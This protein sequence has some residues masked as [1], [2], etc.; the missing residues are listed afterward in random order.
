MSLGGSGVDDGFC[1]APVIGVQTSFK[2]VP[3]ADVVLKLAQLSLAHFCENDGPTSILCTQALPVSCRVCWGPRSVESSIGDLSASAQEKED[4]YQNSFGETE[5]TGDDLEGHTNPA[6]IGDQE[7]KHHTPFKVLGNQGECASCT[8]S[9]P[10][11]YTVKLPPGSPGSPRLD[12]S[13]THGSP[14]LRSRQLIPSWASQYS[15]DSETEDEPSLQHSSPDSFTSDTTASSYHEH[16]LECRTT[17]SPV[18]PNTYSMLRRACIQTLSCEQLPRGL[19]SGRLLFDDQI[20]GLTV[21]WKFRLPDPHA[22]GRYRQYALLA[23]AGHGSRRAMDAAPQIWAS[24][25]RIVNGVLADTERVLNRGKCPYTGKPE[26]SNVSSFLTGRSLDP[27]GFPRRNGVNSMRARSLVEIVGDEYFFPRLHL[28]FTCLLRSLA[29]RFGRV[30][31]QPP[32]DYE[33]SQE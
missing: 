20:N 33:S 18:D 1:Y 14:I 25:E 11:Q 7:V 8:F 32:S 31:L 6:I 19:T 4:G 10:K 30:K 24:F 29:E 16:K 12:G 9:V 2:Q 22:R 5:N 27:D 3:E 28:E 21:A 17:S 26:L 15:D 13:G 23:V